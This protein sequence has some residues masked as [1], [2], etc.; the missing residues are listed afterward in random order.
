MRTFDECV[1]WPERP[2]EAGDSVER[3]A[4]DMAR[5][6]ACTPEDCCG[7]RFACE[8]FGHGGNVGCRDRQSS[9]YGD[10]CPAGVF[11]SDGCWETMC[12]SIRRRCKALGIDL[13]GEADAE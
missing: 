3:L 9:R 6:L 7:I 5:A 2:Q 10:D 8:Y 1:G 4:F 13:G 12:A 11:L